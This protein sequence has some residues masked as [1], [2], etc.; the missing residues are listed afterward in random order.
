MI[1]ADGD[2]INQI[3]EGKAPFNRILTTATDV[4]TFPNMPNALISGGK[5]VKAG[6]KIILD[7]PEGVVIN[8]G[9]NEVVMKARFDPY[10]ST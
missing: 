9:T 3:A 8:K 10:S 5:L 2:M 7:D 1:V 6:C 4:Q